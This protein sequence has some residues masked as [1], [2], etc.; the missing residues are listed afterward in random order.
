M[1]LSTLDGY[2]TALALNPDLI[3]PSEREAMGVKSGFI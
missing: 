1:P 3:P 2:L